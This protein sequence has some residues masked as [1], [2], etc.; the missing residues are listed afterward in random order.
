[1]LTLKTYLR[2]LIT[3]ACILVGAAAGFGI[4]LLILLI[5]E[6]IMQPKYPDLIMGWFYWPLLVC[7]P[8]F[9]VIFGVLFHRISGRLLEAR[10]KNPY[11][12]GK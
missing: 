5:A 6:A 10:H 9:A 7:V 4:A 3:I 1:M 2:N 11:N 12:K 8:L